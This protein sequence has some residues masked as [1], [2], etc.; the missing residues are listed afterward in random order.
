MDG[1]SH[2]AVN[3][4]DF[5]NRLPSR[6]LTKAIVLLKPN[7]ERATTDASTQNLHILQLSVMNGESVENINPEG[8]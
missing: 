8:R 1:L 4:F 6:G 7:K 3:F 2:I 5:Q